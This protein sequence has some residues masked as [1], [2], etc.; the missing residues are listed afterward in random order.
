[1]FW[2]G[3]LVGCLVSAIFGA[4]VVAILISGGNSDSD[5]RTWEDCDD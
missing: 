1:M 5:R 2:I 3:V 4:V